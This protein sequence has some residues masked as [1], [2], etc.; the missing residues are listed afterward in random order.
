MLCDLYLH[1]GKTTKA[2][3][4]DSLAFI[5]INNVVDK[6]NKDTTLHYNPFLTLGNSL[7]VLKPSLAYVHNYR[8]NGVDKHN[9]ETTLNHNPFLT[10]GNAT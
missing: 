10:L 7:L 6:Q 1:H 4:L 9:K 8:N 3:P 2:T 5:Y